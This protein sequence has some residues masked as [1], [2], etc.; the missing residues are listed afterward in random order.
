MTGRAKNSLRSGASSRQRPAPGQRRIREEA[1]HAKATVSAWWPVFLM[2]AL[3]G[4]TTAY[5]WNK[6][7]L[8][9]LARQ[10]EAAAIGVSTLSE[11]RSRLTAAI[12][13]KTKPGLIQGQAQE[14]LGMIFPKNGFIELVL[15]NDETA[16]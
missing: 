8:A 15:E 6:V 5:V 13:V 11:E 12:M 1:R 2:G 9:T 7:E 16:N 10:I 3:V 4:I 14:Q